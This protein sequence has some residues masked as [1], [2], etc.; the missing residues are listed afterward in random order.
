MHKI[1]IIGNGFVGKATLT[2]QCDD[3]EFGNPPNYPHENFLECN[4]AC[5]AFSIPLLEILGLFGLRATRWRSLARPSTPP[6]HLSA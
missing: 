3:I 5:L 1:G 6:G 4:Y 2:L